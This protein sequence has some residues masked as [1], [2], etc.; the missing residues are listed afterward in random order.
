MAYGLP[1]ILIDNTYFNYESRDRICIQTV[2]PDIYEASYPCWFLHYEKVKTLLEQQYI[3]ISEHVNTS[4]L[5][6]DGRKIPYTGILLKKLP[7]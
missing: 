1:Y 3:T 7:A 6:L 2:P 4:G 5:Y